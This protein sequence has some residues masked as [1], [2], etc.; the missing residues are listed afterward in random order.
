MKATQSV[1]F[2]IVDFPRLTETKQLPRHKVL[3]EILA[4]ASTLSLQLKRERK[5]E[6]RY[7]VTPIEWRRI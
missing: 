1:H 2:I 3:L 4:K 5:K 7:T 6:K